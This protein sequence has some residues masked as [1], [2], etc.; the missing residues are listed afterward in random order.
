MSK[1]RLVIT[2]VVVEKRSVV[3]VVAEY[4]VARSWVDELLARWQAAQVVVPAVRRR[5]A[6]RVLAVRLHPLPARRSREVEIISW[7]DDHSRL[8]LHVTAHRRITG[9]IVVSTLR[10]TGSRPAH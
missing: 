5:A 1:A 2:A 4:G 10:S 8:A 6:G 7:L 9:Q 3:Q